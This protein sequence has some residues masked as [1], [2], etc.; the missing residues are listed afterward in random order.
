MRT[1]EYVMTTSISQ[2]GL[3]E[4]SLKTSLF[5]C[6]NWYEQLSQHRFW[7]AELSGWDRKLCLQLYWSSWLTSP[8]AWSYLGHELFKTLSSLCTSFCMLLSAVWFTSQQDTLLCSRHSWPSG[9][10]LGLKHSTKGYP[11]KETEPLC[12]CIHVLCTYPWI[13]LGLRSHATNL[14]QA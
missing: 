14:L 3:E 6:G 2:W 13:A 1:V 7:A 5:N 11:T 10:Q 9:V 12:S 8:P 4:H